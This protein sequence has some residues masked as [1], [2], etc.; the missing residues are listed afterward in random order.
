MLQRLAQIR[1]TP[2]SIQ[3]IRGLG[4]RSPDSRWIGPDWERSAPAW[5]GLD[6]ASP[7]GWWLRGW[8]RGLMA[9]LLFSRES[10]AI[11]K[12]QSPPANQLRWF[13]SDIVIGIVKYDRLRGWDY[14]IPHADTLLGSRAIYLLRGIYQPQEITWRTRFLSSP[15]MN[16]RFVSK[17]AVTSI[18]RLGLATGVGISPFSAS[19]EC[20]GWSLLN[21][22][23]HT[24]SH[25]QKRRGNDRTT[26]DPLIKIYID[27]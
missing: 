16:P 26:N 1:Q 24:S 13:L 12:S 21:C 11:S 9:S 10:L 14:S 6:V 15:I 25:T 18:G 3:I 17:E 22:R 27:G 7:R 20:W 2:V 4:A 23:P 8:F 5:D 19:W